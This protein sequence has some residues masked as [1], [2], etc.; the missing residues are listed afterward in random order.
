MPVA[1]RLSGGGTPEALALRGQADLGE[2]RAEAN[3]TLDLPGGKGSATVTLR[4]PGAP[5]LMAEAFG[6]PL[7]WL[8]EGSF[9]L[10]AHLAA[11]AQGVASENFELVAGELRV[12]GQ[13][14]LATAARPKLTGRIAAQ[15]LPVPL[16]SLRATE[17]LG[18]EVLA[19]FD[20]ELALEAA[21]I[22]AGGAVLEQASAVLNLADGRLALERV[23]ARMDGGALEA[24]LTLDVRRPPQG[25]GDGM[26]PRAS[27]EFRLSDATLAAPLLG[28]PFDLS[29]GR[30][31]VA[32]QL[33]A[34]GH[35]PAG[36]LG[37][38]AGGW[39]AA[40]R[41]GVLTGFDLAAA[42]AA[43]ALPDLPEAEAATRRA[44][45]SGATAFDR[46]DLQGSIAAGRLRIETGRVMTEGGAN[47][48][49]GGEADLPR[50]VLDLRLGVRPAQGDAPEIGLRATGP[51]A[52]PRALPETADWARWRAERG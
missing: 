1:L 17:P 48:T 16:P 44:L 35:A 12:G 9:S 34:E 42:A 19:A 27:L 23:R 38:L 21:R 39:R 6:L 8:G 45:L 22:E 5:R 47:A 29:A 51:A 52:A 37:T 20:A 24:A 15:R 50:G 43:T 46:L 3:G 33:T 2:L 14:A 40:L 28:L 25:G 36:L 13:V 31:E 10:V 49:L 30:G 26:P 32:A 7:P 18:L 41:D 11:S 4:H